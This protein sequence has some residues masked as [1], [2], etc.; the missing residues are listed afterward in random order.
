MR[1][2]MNGAHDR[3]LRADEPTT[4]DADADRVRR[5]SAVVSA[6]TLVVSIANYAFS[7]VLI[8]LL[9][10]PD[11]VA[12]ASAQSLLLVLGS[13]GMAAIPWAVARHVAVARTTRAVSEALGFGLVASVLQGVV[14]AGL[15]FA[16]VT[17][18]SGVELGAATAAA[19]F[20]LSVIAAPLGL[21]Q[22]QSRFL[23]ISALRLVEMVVRIGLSLLL[24]LLVAADPLS[25]VVGFIAGNAVLFVAAL[26][27]CR[28]AFPL[29][30]AALTTYSGLLRHSVL[31]GVAQLALAALGT[32][33]TV[34][35]AMT[36]M[37]AIDARDYQVAALLGRV[38]LYL[39]TALAMTYF[40]IIA[41]AVS[42]EEARSHLRR[43]VRL[44]VV[45]AAPVSILIATTPAWALEIISPERSVE[46]GRLL[47][48]T[49]I[50]GFSV[51]VATV[52]ACARQAR[53]RYGRLFALLVPL[54]AVQPFALF[55]VGDGAGAVGFAA[56]AA[57]FGVLAVA[58]LAV[59][60]RSWQ[61]WSL[62]RRVDVGAVL[63]VLVF[64]T[65]GREIGWLWW[66][67]ATGG[68]V[69]CA[70]VLL[71]RSASTGRIA[72]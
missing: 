59:D 7:L 49:A 33:D 70:W 1:E 13:G 17:P 40:P 68:V 51:A 50:T 56:T 35:I 31:L 10:A 48:L 14:F 64:A 37:S 25:P 55:A 27:A 29:R 5:Q 34:V 47:P 3:E 18:T 72:G 12:Y 8:H 21:L 9:T 23:S 39:G 28:V 58:V 11:Y 53:R 66:V 46:V 71:G 60:L 6:T 2:T 4:V 67:A 52:L 69:L 26:I 32:A 42:A 38:P 61:P 22:G 41:G 20:A 24:L 54:V 45:V 62:V 16:L 63:L 44:I 30:R 19:A 15:A 43:V 57:V 65:V 36:G